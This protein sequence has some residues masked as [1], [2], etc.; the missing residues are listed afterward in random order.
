MSVTRPLT[1]RI[2]RTRRRATAMIA[3]AWLISALL[4]TP[5]IV[6]WPHIE[7]RRTVPADD[8]FL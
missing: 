8:C 4:W 2:R 6:A 1:Y 3:G 7:G 5:W